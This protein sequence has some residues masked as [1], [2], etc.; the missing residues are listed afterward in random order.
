MVMDLKRIA[1]R[2]GQLL[3]VVLVLG[4]AYYARPVDIYSDLVAV[5]SGRWE[6]QTCAVWEAPGSVEILVCWL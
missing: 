6:R 4:V 3:G 2:I 1:K 5:R